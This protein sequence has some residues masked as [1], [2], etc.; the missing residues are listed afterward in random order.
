MRSRTWMKLLKAAGIVAGMLAVAVGLLTATDGLFDV[1]QD[2]GVSRHLTDPSMARLEILSTTARRDEWGGAKSLQRVASTGDIVVAS[3]GGEVVSYDA[4][5]DG[6]QFASVLASISTTTAVHGFVG[7]RLM[8]HGDVGFGTVVTSVIGSALVLPTGAFSQP[9]SFE[10][11]GST[12]AMVGSNG[13]IARAVDEDGG[14]QIELY[15]LAIDGALTSE[16]VISNTAASAL[17]IVDNTLYA[18]HDS[19]ELRVIDISSITAPAV[20]TTVQ[21][22]TAVVGMLSVGSKLVLYGQGLTTVDIVQPWS[23]RVLGSTLVAN[24]LAVVVAADGDV[25]AA[26]WPSAVDPL[27]ARVGFDSAGAPFLR[28]QDS[29]VECGYG[30]AVVSWA[31]LCS[32]SIALSAIT[33]DGGGLLTANRLLPETR[34]WIETV[35]VSGTIVAGLDRFRGVQFHEIVSH[36]L[37]LRDSVLD[38]EAYAE[39]AW[40]GTS[41]F[42]AGLEDFLVVNAAD[43]SNVSV[44]ARIT[45]VQRPTEN[46]TKF[47][48]AIA[49]ADS[50]VAVASR[51]AGVWLFDVSDPSNPYY[52]SSVLTRES[53]ADVLLDGSTLYVAVAGET[54]SIEVFDVVN[55]SLPQHLTT[56]DP[57]LGKEHLSLIPGG[58]VASDYNMGVA[59]FDTS[60]PSTLVLRTRLQL[61]GLN[62]TPLGLL[63][64]D[65]WMAVAGASVGYL[66]DF[67]STADLSTGPELELPWGLT[68]IEIGHDGL[69]IESLG[70]ALILAE[71]MPGGSR[72]VHDAIHN[73]G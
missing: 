66:Y 56:G 19:G 7:E 16:A 9:V 28:W 42:C 8:Y 31:T 58:L 46:Y 3:L 24:D 73:P 48:V 41:L 52:A 47:P 39:C 12:V 49:A 10:V 63:V 72:I 2:N 15:S 35:S 40:S 14:R 34:S 6:L 71:Y 59:S 29:T 65:N 30:L 64:F 57:G 1:T 51:S 25:L 32:D 5:D 54:P 68:D 44:T 18:A 20:I 69:V 53:T 45:D 13:T 17:T 50:L 21:V 37:V 60:I 38:A 22:M 61:E 26:E 55:P 23:P 62:P 67:D 27:L 70:S 43:P 33:H 36:S 11:A 4:S